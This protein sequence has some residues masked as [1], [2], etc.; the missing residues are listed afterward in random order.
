[1]TQDEF[2]RR[3]IGKQWIDRACSF[4]AMDCWGL[5][6]L[7]YRHV[8]G[9]EIHQT[10]DYE[11]GND[12]ITCYENDVNFWRQSAHQPGSL[13]VFFKGE[14]PDHVGIVLA[15]NKCL[16]SLG[17]GKSVSIDRLPVLQRMFTKTE[18]M[19]YASL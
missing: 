5:V 4:D 2:I 11:A 12:F 15:G 6:V 7:Y 18:F 1:M 3:V 8:I 10:P 13:A 17:G 9:I 16:H 19:T 14:N